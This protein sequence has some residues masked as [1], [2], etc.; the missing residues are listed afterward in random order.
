MADES[1][2]FVR[3]VERAYIVIDGDAEPETMPDSSAGII[4]GTSNNLATEPTSYLLNSLSVLRYHARYQ[5]TQS[6]IVAA[7]GFANITS[8][9]TYLTLHGR[10][11]LGTQVS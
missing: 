3:F 8:N 5:V 9:I 7:T 10:V 1:A 11:Y 6:K 2:L 4:P